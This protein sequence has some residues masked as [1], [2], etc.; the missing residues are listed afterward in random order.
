MPLRTNTT[1]TGTAG[2]TMGGRPSP[3]GGRPGSRQILVG[4]ELYLWLLVA[5]ELGAIGWLRH[6]FRRRHGG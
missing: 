1:P 5:L 4:D 6:Q 3:A 2:G